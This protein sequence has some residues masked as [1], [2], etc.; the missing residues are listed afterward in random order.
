MEYVFIGIGGIFG[1]IS[2]YL[3]GRYITSKSGTSFPKGTF[4]I[5]LSG[6]FLLGMLVSFN[7]SK[8]LYL[9]LGEG[10]LGAYTTFSTFIYESINLINENDKINLAIYILCSI[11]FGVLLFIT[12]NRIGKML[13]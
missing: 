8:N 1:S 13:Q 10:F 7:V 12:G 3:F 9:L 6:A 4:I 11:I 2:R 5:N